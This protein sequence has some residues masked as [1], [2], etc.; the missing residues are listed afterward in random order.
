M[1]MPDGGRTGCCVPLGG[2]AQCLPVAGA[3]TP[4]L[5]RFASLLENTMR[6]GGRGSERAHVVAPKGCSLR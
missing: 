3:H 6:P 2:M 4:P 5:P 1:R